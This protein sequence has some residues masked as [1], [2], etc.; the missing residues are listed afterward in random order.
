M[1]YRSAYLDLT[2][3]YS[4]G[5]LDLFY[6]STVLN[7]VMPN[8]LAFLFSYEHDNMST[9]DNIKMSHKLRW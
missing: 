4:K 3:A 5:K 2:F 1:D 8:I 6:R 7:S 9:K